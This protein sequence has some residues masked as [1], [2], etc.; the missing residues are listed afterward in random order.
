MISHHKIVAC[1]ECKKVYVTRVGASG[2]GCG[3][4]WGFVRMPE[5]FG[6]EALKEM[7]RF[8]AA[9]TDLQPAVAMAA[10]NPLA[11]H[12]RWTNLTSEL[13]QSGV[14]RVV[15]VGSR[16]RS[17]EHGTTGTIIGETDG[18]TELL[19]AWDNGG[20][21]GNVCAGKKETRWELAAL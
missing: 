9:I 1:K 11:L 7:E 18:N 6:L 13:V 3:R 8:V 21:Q 10:P 16:V 5:S 4:T 2:C 20:R 15:T 14:A 12:E 19:V 17:L